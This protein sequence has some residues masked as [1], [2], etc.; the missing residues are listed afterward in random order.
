MQHNL[1]ILRFCK[2]VEG[3][4]SICLNHCKREVGWKFNFYNVSC[5]KKSG[6]KPAPQQKNLQNSV[7]GAA[8]QINY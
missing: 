2:T 8:S 7:C 4:F 1:H 3:M 5:L 6:W